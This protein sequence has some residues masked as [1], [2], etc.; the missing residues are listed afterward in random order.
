MTKLSL[1]HEEVVKVKD[2]KIDELKEMMLR[3]EEE[4][5]KDQQYM[6]SLGISLKEVKD[7]NEEL[8]DRNNELLDCNKELKSD[9]KKV[10]RKP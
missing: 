6:R 9:V 3:Q 8:L 5:K 10:Q 7:Q 2:D 1:E 4:R